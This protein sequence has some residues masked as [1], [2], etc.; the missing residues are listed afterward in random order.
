MAAESMLSGL[1][2]ALL[3][4]GADVGAITS[5]K[6]RKHQPFDYILVVDVEATCERERRSDFSNE[7]IELPVCILTSTGEILADEFHV[8]VRP[9][10]NPILT[11]FCTELT[12]IEQETVDSAIELAEAL[13]QLQ[14][15]VAERGLFTRERPAVF[16]CDGPW[17]IRDF[18]KKETA[19]KGI[20]FPPM[21]SEWIDLRAA[22]RSVTGKFGNVAAMLS[23]LSLTFLGREHSGL[24]DTRNIARI[25]R[26]LLQRGAVLNVNRRLGAA[27]VMDQVAHSR[28]YSRIA[29]QMHESLRA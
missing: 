11:E 22:H 16:A 6:L 3:E 24:D 18:I 19:R 26:A 21:M 28:L 29:A 27:R 2:A 1:N 10:E 12:G 17:D 9:T 7:I 20:P 23:N 25:G 15:W 5:S 13:D 8:F 14:A 4:Q